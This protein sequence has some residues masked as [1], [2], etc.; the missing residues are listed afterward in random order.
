[1]HRKD[2]LIGLFLGVVVAVWGTAGAV[3]AKGPPASYAATGWA[4]L[5]A[6]AA[7]SSTAGRGCYVA[8]DRGEK[9]VNAATTIAG[10]TYFG[11]NRPSAAVPATNT[12]TADLGVAKSYA[13]PLF[14]VSPGTGSTL[15][16]GG[17]PPSPVAGIVLVTKTDSV[18]KKTTTKQVPFCIGCPN[19]K[20]S[21]IEASR[22]DPTINVP[23]KRIYWNPET[24]R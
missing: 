22:V 21:G 6:A 18:T 20:L 19:P 5:H 9:V 17:L 2:R 1:M 16:G 12:C 15:K 8:L 14:C 10:S 11:T 4:D 13:M 7:S 3:W 23:R 24:Q